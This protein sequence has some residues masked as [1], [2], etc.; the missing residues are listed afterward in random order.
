LFLNNTGR[1]K[2]NQK[3][4]F[5]KNIIAMTLIDKYVL[6]QFL[7][8]VLFGL[9]TFICIF[10]V[11]DMME[12]LDNF[13]DAGIGTGMTIQ[14]YLY[15][16]PEIIKLMLPVSM[17]LSSLFTMGRL[18]SFNELT[19]IKS[20]GVS[21]YRFLIPFLIVAVIISIFS[22][23][24]NGWVV[25]YTNKKKFAIDRINMHRRIELVNRDNLFLQDRS[26]SLLCLGYFDDMNGT[27]TRVSIQN[28][29]DTNLTQMVSRYDAD[30]MRWVPG[31]S[32][33]LL[34]NVTY[35][36]MENNQE[37]IIKYDTVPI[38]LNFNPEQIIK[39]QQKP[40][41]MNYYELGAFI[42]SK[43]RS[44]YDVSKWMV[45]YYSKISFPFA[46]VIVVL[47]GIPFGINKKRSGLSV[48]FGISL[49][50]CFIYLVFMK[51][52]QVF[53]YNGDLNPMLTAWLANILF[54]VSA[55]INIVRIKK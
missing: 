42:D 4:M 18:S 30:Q 52:S 46:S 24:F 29:S 48:Q 26:N 20:A 38:K 43:K 37:K 21:V 2:I 49:M 10:V 19:A 7:M 51:I 17:L 45:E 28:Y 22:I 47:F 33:W 9:L 13:I 27:A 3:I 32:K 50:V 31:E 16:I 54:L 14:Y 36:V 5:K 39:E 23:Y 6:K 34:N 35:R 8:N 15:F 1:W 25:P 40:D 12:N 11:V 53:G 41:E 55:I 44:G